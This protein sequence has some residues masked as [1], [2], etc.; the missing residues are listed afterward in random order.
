[1]NTKAQKLEA[2]S[3]LL[4]I[5]DE[6]REQCPWDKKQTNESLR[7]LTLEEVYELSDALIKA[8]H[9][10]IKKEL[11]DVL[12]HLVFYAKIASETQ[13]FD[14]ADVIHSLC[15][16][17]IFR[18]PHIY[19][20]TKV[21]DADEVSRNWEFLKLKEGHSSVL[22]GVPK[23]LPT[24]IK[25]HRIQE[26]ARGVGFDFNNKKEAWQKVLEEIKEFETEQNP[27][28]QIDE[29]GDVMFSIV[30]YARF[31]NIHADDALERTNQKFLNRFG[32]M[33]EMMK[34]QQLSFSDLKLHQMDEL[35]EK[36]KQILGKHD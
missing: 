4:D 35:W 33:E 31:L 10:E 17:L 18:H 34:E 28:K 7:G 12:L 30:N 16:K 19:S 20:D 36:A 3:R 14:I 8:D 26:K 11:G 15:E 23:S 32:L 24:L 13:T 2:F 27:E 25:A 29:L 21:K 6:L 22:S 1:M 5:M 9:L